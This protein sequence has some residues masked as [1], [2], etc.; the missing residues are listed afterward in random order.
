[1]LRQIPPRRDDSSSRGA[2]G[3]VNRRKLMPAVVLFISSQDGSV[4]VITKELADGCV[5]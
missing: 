2:D 3:T 1:M 5:V 4:E